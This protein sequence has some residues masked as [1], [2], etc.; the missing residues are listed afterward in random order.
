MVRFKIILILS[1]CQA[2]C[3]ILVDIVYLRD[4]GELMRYF[5]NEAIIERC[6][7]VVFSP[8]LITRDNP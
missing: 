5:V 2:E 1:R 3:E 6:K 7:V 8:G 4:D